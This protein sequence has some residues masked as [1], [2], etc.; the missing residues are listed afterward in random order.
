MKKYIL[1]LLIMVNGLSF[2]Q[3]AY[4]QKPVI[5]DS[6]GITSPTETAVADVN[7]DGFKDIIVAG[8]TKI[9]WFKNNNGSGNFSNCN[10]ITDAHSSYYNVVAGDLDGDTY[11]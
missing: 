3:V 7:N 11:I 1:L 4:E 8:S 10:L 9:G 5:D 2:A 6:F